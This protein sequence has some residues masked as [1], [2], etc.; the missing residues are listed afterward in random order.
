MPK[1]ACCNIVLTTF[2][3]SKND[4]V[5]DYDND[6]ELT[7]RKKKKFLYITTLNNDA[8]SDYDN[9]ARPKNYN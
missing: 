2:L 8:V 6:A 1:T 9:D 4:A 3:R 7:N 5:Y